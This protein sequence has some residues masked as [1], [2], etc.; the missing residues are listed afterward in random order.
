MATFGAKYPAFKA[1]GADA[2]VSIGKLV[3]ANL[4]VN[5]ASGELYADDALAEQ[6]SEFAS[7]SIAMET[8]DMTDDVASV[9]YGS[10]VINKICTYNTGDT[11]PEGVLGYYKALMR[12]GKKLYKGFVYTRCKASLGN[13]N[14]STKGSSIT[15]GTTS[16]TFTV[17]PD[18]NGDWRKTQE[19]DT[20]AAAKTWIDT[21]CSIA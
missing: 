17:M 15:F 19:F 14:A 8:D 18:S 13:D 20:E 1:T 9:V 21:E 2:G 5:L 7:G 4:T 3:S 16:T 6:V 10:T 12:D 11:A